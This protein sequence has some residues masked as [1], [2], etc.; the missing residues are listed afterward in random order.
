MISKE[1][2]L[3]KAIEKLQDLKILTYDKKNDVVQITDHFRAHYFHHLQKYKN[4][5]EA[6]VY[7]LVCECHTVKEQELIDYCII[8]QSAVMLLEKKKI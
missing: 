4:E 7:S 1:K 8:I 2:R 6:L 3:D 5:K